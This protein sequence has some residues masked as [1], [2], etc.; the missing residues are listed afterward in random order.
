MK[1]RILWRKEIAP[2]IVKTLSENPSW[3]FPTIRS[4]F[5]Y[6]SDS[7]RVV[8]RTE[9]SYKKIDEVTVWLRKTGQIPF[10][11]FKVMRG[12]SGTYGNISIPPYDRV[13]YYFRRLFEVAYEYELPKLWNQPYVLEVW[14]EKKGLL[15]TFEELT[16][17][18]DIK[19]RSTEGYSPWEFCNSAVEE[20]MLLFDERKEERLVVL[21]FSDADPSGLQIQESVIDQFEHFEI[22]AKVERCGVT[23]EQIKNYRLPES[24]KDAETLARIGR[25]PN[26]QK[27][28]RRYGEVFCELDSFISLAP[29]GFRGA[30]YRAIERHIDT[31]LMEIRDKE[32]K[33]RKAVIKEIMEEYREELEITRKAIV[34][35]LIEDIGD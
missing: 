19:V 11:A 8:P 12:V 23:L 5:Y 21:F 32:N 4:M 13:D 29:D 17:K 35:R 15:P 26:L 6:L 28:V 31:D 18:Y 30:L 1:K 14:V 16:R 2:L 7:L 27:Y 25:D 10:G 34:G 24:P 9:Q 20:I 3:R 33:R 22:D